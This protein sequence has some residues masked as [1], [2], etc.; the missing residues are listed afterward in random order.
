MMNSELPLGQ[1]KSWTQE[2]DSGQDVGRR[3][4]SGKRL[5]AEIRQNLSEQIGVDGFMILDE[6]NRLEASIDNPLEAHDFRK[7]ILEAACRLIARDAEKTRTILRFARM[8]ARSKGEKPYITC[9][10]EGDEEA[11]RY[12][13]RYCTKKVCL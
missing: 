2:E 10:F 4:D 5:A 13:C 1:K 8:E 9:P 6:I 7:S 11:M 3:C 12:A